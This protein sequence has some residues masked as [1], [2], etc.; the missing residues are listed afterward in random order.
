MNK[1]RPLLF[2]MKTI[3]ELNFRGYNPE[4]KSPNLARN[5]NMNYRIMDST[6]VFF[7]VDT[8]LCEV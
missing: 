1:Y 7:F 2:H 3:R 5:F 6:F 8:S 4:E